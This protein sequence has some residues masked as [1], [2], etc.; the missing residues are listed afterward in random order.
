MAKE[1]RH[2]VKLSVLETFPKGMAGKTSRG[3]IPKLPMHFEEIL[4]LAT[5]NLQEKNEALESS[6]ITNNYCIIIINV[7]NIINA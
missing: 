5:G 4:L 2:V 3:P 1:C 6:V 7:Y